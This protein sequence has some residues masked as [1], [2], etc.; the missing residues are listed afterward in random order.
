MR[1]RIRALIGLERLSGYA[2][3]RIVENCRGA[4]AGLPLVRALAAGL[5][6]AFRRYTAGPIYEV[7]ILTIP[8]RLTVPVG[9]A[10]ELIADD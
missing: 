6:S 1:I 3:R 4:A 5:E 7:H 10:I 9:N 2:F 8:V